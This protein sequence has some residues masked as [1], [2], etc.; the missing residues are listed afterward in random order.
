MKLSMEVQCYQ[1]YNKR[2]IHFDLT[3]FEPNSDFPFGQ[4]MRPKNILELYLRYRSI[5]C[6]DVSGIPL[7][8]Y[9]MSALYF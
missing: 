3:L 4:L 9:A 1:F 6:Q 5:S 2:P 7:L 8:I